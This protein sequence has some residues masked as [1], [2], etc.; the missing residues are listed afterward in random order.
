MTEIRLFEYEKL[1]RNNGSAEALEPCP[2]GP[3]YDV[4]VFDDRFGI[5][6]F[7]RPREFCTVDVHT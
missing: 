7:E 3:V 2:A 5:S 6:R 4:C 1:G